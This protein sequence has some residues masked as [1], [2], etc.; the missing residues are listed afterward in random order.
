MNRPSDRMMGASVKE[1]W[2]GHPGRVV[3]GILASLLALVVVFVARSSAHRTDVPAGLVTEAKGSEPAPY[4]IPSELVKA[5]PSAQPAPAAAP[6]PEPAEDPGE[7]SA[8]ADRPLAR[9]QAALG[10][11]NVGRRA[12]H[13][14]AAGA[15]SK[16]ARVDE[17]A[18]P[19]ATTT[20]AAEATKTGES[21]KN[22][23]P[24]V[25]D[26]RRVNILE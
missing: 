24:L 11:A 13:A 6:S 16:V 1:K 7:D 19:A 8:I 26:R 15:R 22:R 23:V 14:H 20:P 18:P 17:A 9:K 12:A 21:A 2:R 3:A 4:A 25:D 10:N 5:L